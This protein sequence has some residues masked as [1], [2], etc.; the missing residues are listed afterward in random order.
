[1]KAK[2][3]VLIKRKLREHGYP[4]DLQPKAIETVIKQAEMLAAEWAA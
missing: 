1:M 2:L 3:K 4:P